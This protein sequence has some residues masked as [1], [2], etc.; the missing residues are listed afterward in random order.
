[1]EE[2]NLIHWANYLMPLVQGACV[3]ITFAFITFRIPL[4][5]RG[6]MHYPYNIPGTL[7]LFFLF[8]GFAIYGTHAGMIVSPDGKLVAVQGSSLGKYDAILNF[9]D[10]AVLV[11]GFVMGPA[12]GLFVGLVAG[13][14]R[15]QLGGFTAISCGLA[16]AIVGLLAG[17]AHRH[18]KGLITPVYA[19]LI[20]S[21][22]V[23]LQKMLIL[24]LSEPAY[25]AVQLVKKTALPMWIINAGGCYLFIYVIRSLDSERREKL[26]YFKAQIEPHFMLNTLNAIRSLIR[27]DPDGARQYVTQF[28]KFMQETQRYATKYSLSI[29]EELEQIQ[30]YIDFQQL[31]FPNKITLNTEISADFPTDYR[32]PPRTLLTLVENSI[33]HGRNKSRSLTVLI[34]LYCTN[35][36][37]IIEVE[38]N[39]KGIAPNKLKQLG[40]D[41]VSSNHQGGGNAVYNI[42][43]MLKLSYGI[44]AKMQISS[45]EQKGTLIRLSLPTQPHEVNLR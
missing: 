42:V 37:N 12:V 11:S 27:T 38:D 19:A 10:M 15:Y 6:L 2:L 41:V 21:I 18:S 40:R 7:L 5:R 3:I 4:L 35:Q 14:E 39:G 43:Q 25:M 44:A 17:I 36:H 34:R 45:E 13:F 9:R 22:A 29:R 33:T 26:A 23:L 8:S 31:R 32:L 16:T 24:W 28:G 30:R 1:M 20:A